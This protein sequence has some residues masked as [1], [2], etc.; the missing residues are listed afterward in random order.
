MVNVQ[1]LDPKYHNREF[2]GGKTFEKKSCYVLV[3]AKSHIIV[4]LYL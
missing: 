2:K 1:A 3:Y 4:Q